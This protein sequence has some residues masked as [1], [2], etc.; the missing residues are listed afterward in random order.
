MAFIF[1]CRYWSPL[2]NVAQKY[3]YNSGFKFSA[4]TDSYTACIQSVAKSIYTGL[5]FVAIVLTIT[6]NMGL[7]QCKTLSGTT[8]AMGKHVVLIRSSQTEYLKKHWQK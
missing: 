1:N 4:R 2:K 6:N 5:G 7:L 3:E 8:T